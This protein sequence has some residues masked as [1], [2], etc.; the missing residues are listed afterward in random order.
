VTSGEQAGKDCQDDRVADLG[1]HRC[2]YRYCLR[3]LG[4]RLRTR[5]SPFPWLAVGSGVLAAAATFTSMRTRRALAVAAALFVGT[6]VGG[7]MLL[8]GLLHWVGSCTA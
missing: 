8:I 2:A 7:G 6:G 1:R 3:D 4:R 5:D